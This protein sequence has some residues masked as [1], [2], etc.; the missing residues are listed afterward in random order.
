MYDGHCGYRRNLSTLVHLFVCLSLAWLDHLNTGAP[1]P[2]PFD[3][4]IFHLSKH[5]AKVF[6][7]YYG[8][9]PVLGPGNVEANKIGGGCL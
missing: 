9:G 6:W 8:S 4:V 7:Q 1:I 3:S 2:R 5:F